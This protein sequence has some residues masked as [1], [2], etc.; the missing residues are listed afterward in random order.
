[1]AMFPLQFSS[2]LLSAAKGNIAN[3][4]F[5]SALRD[6]NDNRYFSFVLRWLDLDN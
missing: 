6:A 5:S 1:M 4:A 3:F 2:L